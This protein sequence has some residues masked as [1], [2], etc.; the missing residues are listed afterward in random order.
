MCKRVFMESKVEERGYNFIVSNLILSQ[1]GEFTYNDIL[2]KLATMMEDVT[3]TIKNIVKSC[4]SRLSD[5]GFL[6]AWDDK[7]SV[8]ELEF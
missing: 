5:D 6:S 7:Y 4:L 1:T 3:Q 8:T 2:N